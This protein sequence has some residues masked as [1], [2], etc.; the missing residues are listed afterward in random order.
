M[1]RTRFFALH[2]QLLATWRFIIP[3]SHGLPGLPG[4]PRASGATDPKDHAH[5]GVDL[6]WCRASRLCGGLATRTLGAGGCIVS[7][8]IP[9]GR[10]ER[11]PW[12]W[13]KNDITELV[14][15]WVDFLLRGRV[16]FGGGCF[17]F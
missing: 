15:L 1:L 9:A 11:V 5:L 12:M 7:K 3:S 2:D 10:G 8:R 14:Q 4:L 16:I 17:D 6:W 13:G